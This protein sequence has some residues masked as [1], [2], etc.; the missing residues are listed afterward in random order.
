MLPVL[1]LLLSLP[2]L[3]LSRPR[4]L[5]II[6]GRRILPILRLLL[7]IAILG[8]IL[9]LLRPVIVVRPRF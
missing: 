4:L 7:L 5:A 9:R 3:L 6:G 8:R 2:R 1:R